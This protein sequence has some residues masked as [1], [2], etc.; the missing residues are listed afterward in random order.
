MLGTGL[1]FRAIARFMAVLTAVMSVAL[2]AAQAQDAARSMPLIRDA[3]IEGLLRLYTRPIFKAAGINPS[4]VKVYVISDRRINAFVAGGQRIFINTGLLLQSDTPN[5][6]IGVLAH[7]TGHIAGG[8]LAR[9]GVEI[10]SANYTSIIGMLLGLAAIAGGVA[11]GNA[12]VAQAGQGIMMGTKGLAQRNFLTYARGMEASADQA[13]LKYL[14]A[15]HQS[16]KGM[17]TLFDTLAREN[18]VALADV[19]PYVLSHPMPVDRIHNLELAA[20]KSPYWN[21][22]DPPA[23]IL[24]HQLVQAKLTGY[25]G[26]AQAVMQ[27]YPSADQSMPARYARA[28]AMFRKG[29]IRNALTII[30]GLTAELPENPYFWELKGQALLE[31]GRAAE[32]VAP[33]Q[34]ALTLLPN[35]GLIQIL[36]AQAY[37][38]TDKPDNAKAAIKLLKQA[39]RSEGET[40]ETYMLLARAY[41][42]TG[43]IPRAELATA[44]SALLRGDKKLAMEKARSA[45]SQFKMGTP[46]WIRANDVLTFAGHK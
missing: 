34:K 6:V 5:E 1:I 28:I 18:L 38:D 20:E 30:D 45:Q 37:I 17:I 32:A 35:N 44:Q 11:A 12:E 31:N 8:H 42:Q 27:K 24:R 16:A 22:K 25:I 13:A 4:A 7:E 23:L 14:N 41:A 40:P 33:V 39:Q 43:D 46:E 10:D 29:D 26:G 21:T 3:E 9:M 2:T 15:T 36:A 19:D